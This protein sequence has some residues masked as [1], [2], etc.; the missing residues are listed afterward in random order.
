[1]AQLNEIGLTLEHLVRRVETGILSSRRTMF[2]AIKAGVVSGA[3][4]VDGWMGY[5]DV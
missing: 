1:M 3:V 2:T 4:T 5:L